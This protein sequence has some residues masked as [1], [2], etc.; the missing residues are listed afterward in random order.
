MTKIKYV[1]GFTSTVACILSL[2]NVLRPVISF[3]VPANMNSPHFPTFASTLTTMHMSNDD[4]NPDDLAKLRKKRQEI[5]AKKKVTPEAITAAPEPSDI[6]EVAENTDLN[7]LPKLERPSILQSRVAAKVAAEAAAAASSAKND[8]K[9]KKNTQS[10]PAVGK[11]IDYLAD[12]EDENELHIP[13]RIGFS[14]AAWGDESQGFVPSSNKKLKKKEIAAGKFV[15]GDL[16]VRKMK[17]VFCTCMHTE[18][19]STLIFPN[20]DNI[21]NSLS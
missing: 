18:I 8:D 6:L 13:N 20:L 11:G 9:E 19:S 15:P 5:L 17:Y 4:F 12:Y 10:S 21:F 3:N 1:T 2:M 14:T 16:Q 7:A